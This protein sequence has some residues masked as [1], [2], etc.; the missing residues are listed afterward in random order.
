MKISKVILLTA[1]LV[2]PVLASARMP[3]KRPSGLKDAY[4]KHFMIGVAVNQRNIRDSVQT[5]LICREFNSIT[6][7]N[8]M[9][10]QPTEPREGQ[11]FWE[12][13]DRVA[14]FCRENGIRLRGHCLVWHN[15]IGE[16]IYTDSAGNEATKELVLE[17]IRN[18][19]RTVVNR[20][21]DVVYCWDVVNEA[22]TDNPKAENPFRQSRLY[23]ICGD[24]FIREAF[25]AAREA[26]PN[27]LLF[28]N[29]YNECDSMKSLRI[30]E[31]VKGMKEDGVP[32]DGIGMQ[33]HYNIYSPKENEVERAINMY[34]SI[35]DHIHVT[36][37]DVRINREQGGQLQ[38]S[39]EGFT[40]S[41]EIKELQEKQYETLFRVFRKHADVIDCVTFWNLSDR[42]SW[43]GA[44][45]YPLLF[46]V[47]YQPKCA[48]DIVKSFKP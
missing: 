8:D 16:W 34:K 44:Q 2:L 12:R 1:V 23:K 33:G 18:H 35:V 13:A 42:D 5:N 15:Q 22:I 14:N 10:P 46:D 48:Y 17:R 32:I 40:I 26:D 25:R 21:K 38:F 6:A 30:Y 37:L 24:E 39:R 11:F 3:R 31:M 43:L 41:D 28:Y 45:N 19:I 36:E 29:D 20:Y 27:T 47:D 7:E 9:K 4:R